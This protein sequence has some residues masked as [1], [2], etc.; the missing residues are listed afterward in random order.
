MGGGKSSG[1][2]KSGSKGASKAVIKS[3]DK[4]KV[5][6]VK[7]IEKRTD[8]SDGN[9]PFTHA[10]FIRFH[11]PEKGEEL[12]EAGADTAVMVEAKKKG[13]G[14]GKKKEEAKKKV[15]RGGGAASSSKSQGKQS[16]KIV[17]KE[18]DPKSK[19][20]GKGGKKGTGTKGGQEKRVDPSDGNGPF[21]KA[22]FVRFHGE[23]KGLS[24]WNQAGKQASPGKKAPMKS[25]SSAGKQASPGKKAP[26]KSESPGKN[27]FK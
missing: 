13:K 1:K 10:S 21:T 23:E 20:K 2:K 9:G 4:K 22:S 12:W 26:M 27:P 11:G 14:K 3:N 25:G 7:M 18:S 16:Q 5:D 15:E 6:E 17:K 8:P 24:L 19:S